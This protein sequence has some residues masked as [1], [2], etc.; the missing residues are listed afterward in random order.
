MNVH[1]RDFF[2][3]DFRTAASHLLCNLPEM[4]RP[5]ARSG[6]RSFVLEMSSFFIFFCKVE[7]AARGANIDPGILPATPA[8]D[9]PR[10]DL[11]PNLNPETTASVI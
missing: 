6:G 10:M 5:R 9:G 3:G 8:A 1:N 11:N 7:E 4:L 2:Q